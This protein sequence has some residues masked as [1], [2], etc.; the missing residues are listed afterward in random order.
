MYFLRFYVFLSSV[1]YVYLLKEDGDED[2]C[3]LLKGFKP[4]VSVELRNKGFHRE[5]VTSVELGSEAPGDVRA[6]LVYTWP[7]GVYLDPNQLASLRDLRDWQML[8]NTTIDLEE[9]AQRTS[10]FLT[11]VYPPQT[12]PSP[13][14]LTVTIPVHGR[15]H[16]PSFDGKSFTPVH[17]ELPELLLWTEKCTPFQRLEPHR[18]LDAPCNASN[19]SICSWIQIQHTHKNSKP[20]SLHLPVGD[21]SAVTLVCAGTLLVTVICC[22][23]LCHSILK[24]QIT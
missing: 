5:V 9:P 16:K 2:L 20:L 12:G 18:L 13:G 11:Y 23:V 14:P 15:Y 19:T 7:R 22:A 8:F 4:S 6:L 21:G 24:H 1:V 3:S 17:I 10:A